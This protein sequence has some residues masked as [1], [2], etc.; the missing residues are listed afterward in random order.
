MPQIS[1]FFGIL[2]YMYFNDH[3]PAHFH[4]EYGEHEAVYTIET[5]EVLRGE[6]P[7]RAHSMVVEW[8]TLYRNELRDNWSRAR[9]MQSL[10][11]IDPLE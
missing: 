5:L 1:R 6:L 7:R 8:A 2:I 3:A 9:E 10:E 11:N 4:A